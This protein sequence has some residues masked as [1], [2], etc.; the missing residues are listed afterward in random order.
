MWKLPRTTYSY[1]CSRHHRDILFPVP[2]VYQHN[3]YAADREFHSFKKVI[4]EMGA[5]Y[6][7][8]EMASFM[9]CSKGELRCR[10]MM[11]VGCVEGGESEMIRVEQS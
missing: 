2:Q 1:P 6:N 9:S 7:T 10:L 8:M 11:E 5:P 4:S 3:V